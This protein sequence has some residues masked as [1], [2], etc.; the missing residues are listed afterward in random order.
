M[1][2]RVGVGVASE[3]PPPGRNEALPI[4]VSQSMTV[5]AQPQH[6]PVPVASAESWHGLDRAFAHGPR[7]GYRVSMR[8]RLVL[9]RLPSPHA[10]YGEFQP[11]RGAADLR[12]VPRL[13]S[14]GGRFRCAELP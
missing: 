5:I 1:L 8:A 10:A 6:D 9:H 12:D 11:A 3:R 14:G 7:L 13:L 2:P 4:Q